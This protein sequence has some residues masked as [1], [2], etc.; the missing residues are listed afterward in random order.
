MEGLS[1]RQ[2]TSL[3]L[4]LALIISLL[5]R[6]NQQVKFDIGEILTVVWLIYSIYYKDY[7]VTLICITILVYSLSQ[8]PSEKAMAWP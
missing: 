1:K 8:S 5:P 6:T 2:F 3:G 4:G 7:L